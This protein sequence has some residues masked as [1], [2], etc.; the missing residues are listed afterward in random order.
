M[1]NLVDNALRHNVP[2]GSA[3]IVVRTRANDVELSVVNTGPMVPAAEVD[4]L[5]QPFQRL[6]GDR[7]GHGE[8]LGLGLSIVAAIANG[9]DATLEVKPGAEGGLDVSVGFA[10]APEPDGTPALPPDAQAV[11]LGLFET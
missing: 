9:H 3:R 6:A 5:L 8:G 1:S 10:R 2:G 4:R 11:G 7:V